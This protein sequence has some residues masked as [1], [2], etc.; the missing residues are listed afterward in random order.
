MDSGKRFVL[1]KILFVIFLA[2]LVFFANV[3]I[4]VATYI[5]LF[6][7]VTARVVLT[8]GES[9][10][11]AWL[12]ISYVA[13]VVLQIIMIANFTLG[14]G[15]IE[16]AGYL[17]RR[18][19]AVGTLLLPILVSRYVIAGKYG[20]FHMPSVE[21]AT[22]IG[23]STF[24]SAHDIIKRATLVANDTK[25]K[26]CAKNLKESAVE[27]MRHDSFNYINN[28][29]LNE[30]YFEKAAQSMD[31][32][33]IYIIVSKTGSPVSEI[34]SIFTQKQY[35]HASLSFDADLQTIISYNGGERVYPP[36]L[37]A[38]M[39]EY[40]HKAD[41]ARILVYSLPC[42]PEK[43][44]M[45]L[46]KVAEIN[47]EGSAY[48]MIGL[49]VNRSHKPNIMYCSQFVYTMLHYAGIAHFT[50]PNGKV[51]N[52]TDLIEQDYYKKLTF[53]QEITF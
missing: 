42:P 39:I 17:L 9:S 30:S 21:D 26:L 34:I 27:L 13:V 51:V 48:N 47:S 31:D 6:V 53:V 38:E 19:L 25:K 24:F 10:T 3:T 23:L 41:D 1:L 12:I 16:G 20:H 28:G 15:A 4:F 33:N 36:G 50:K 46:N 52:P 37:N 45:L 29:S 8:P 35:N 32:P 44:Q 5:V 22:T 2:G 7:F 11:K 49:F 14:Y 40:L 18:L 43:K